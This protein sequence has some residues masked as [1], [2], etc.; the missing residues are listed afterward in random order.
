MQT[1]SFPKKIK[2]LTASPLTVAP[3]VP[4]T[5]T[6]TVGEI[7]E[8]LH[9]IAPN[10]FAT[11]ERIRHWTREHLLLPV[12]QHHGG[13]G[14]HRRYAAESVY[15]AAILTVIADAGLPIITQGYLRRALP[16]ARGA[17]LKWKARGKSQ[18]VPLFLEISQIPKKIRGPK[19]RIHEGAVKQD[20]T[21][22]LSLI[23]NLSNI[24]TRVRKEGALTSAPKRPSRA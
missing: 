12:D 13:T 16:L 23:I 15:D 17:L 2:H 20:P 4:G 19:I 6:L 10:S 21:A 1:M 14:K 22:A 18:D 5:P 11:I 9:A 7:A 24:F 8:Q 3:P